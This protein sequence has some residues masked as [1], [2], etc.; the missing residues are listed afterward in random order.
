MGPFIE[1]LSI[2]R[3]SEFE[4][5]SDSEGYIYTFILELTKMEI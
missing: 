5:R 1:M 2:D 4:S 3:P